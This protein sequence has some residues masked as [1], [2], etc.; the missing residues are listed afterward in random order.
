MEVKHEPGGGEL[1]TVRS[2]YDTTMQTA[3][4]S[5]CFVLFCFLSGSLSLE[6]EESGKETKAYLQAKSEKD[7]IVMAPRSCAQGTGEAA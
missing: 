7:D 5:F 2:Q 3:P 1:C 6:L 4:G